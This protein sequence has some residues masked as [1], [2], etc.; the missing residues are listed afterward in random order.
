MLQGETISWSKVPQSCFKCLRWRYSSFS[1]HAKTAGMKMCTSAFKLG[2]K[3]PFYIVAFW[4]TKGIAVFSYYLCWTH[5][6]CDDARKEWL[7]IHAGLSNSQESSNLS[8]LVATLFSKGGNGLHNPWVTP[9]E[10]P[11]QSTLEV[12]ED[13]VRNDVFALKV[14]RRF[15][16]THVKYAIW[17]TNHLWMKW[18]CLC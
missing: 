6:A 14:V 7:G 4:S 5:N 10:F 17:N 16:L 1:Y 15:I 8:R 12:M 9:T 11:D 3:A 18:Q 13:A 2:Q